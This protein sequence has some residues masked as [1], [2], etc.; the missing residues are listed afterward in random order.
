MQASSNFTKSI[1]LC[2]YLNLKD[3][4]V[5][6]TEF[7]ESLK[8]NPVVVR[9]L[10]ALLKKHQIIGSVAGAH[11]GFFL[12]RSAENITLWDIYLSVREDN[13][14]NRPKVNPSCVVS[15]NLAVLVHDV[16]TEAEMSM[17]AILD[18]TNIAAL[19][20]KLQNILG[21]KEAAEALERGE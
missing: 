9:R 2:I 11:G 5:S 16:F 21:E 20:E 17:K 3:R 13:F 4:L 19:T 15:S 12:E 10:I 1:H 6:S 8:T 18:K 14:F 7:A